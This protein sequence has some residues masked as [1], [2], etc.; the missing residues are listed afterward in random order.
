MSTLTL[1]VRSKTQKMKS[2]ALRKDKISLTTKIE[3]TK[4]LGDDEARDRAALLT[5]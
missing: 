1:H 4:R 2:G 5:A 3:D